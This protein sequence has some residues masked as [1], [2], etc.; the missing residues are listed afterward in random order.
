MRNTHLVKVGALQDGSILILVKK[1]EMVPLNFFINEKVNETH[2][3]LR[4]RDGFKEGEEFGDFKYKF[5]YLDT[6][7]N[8]YKRI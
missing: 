3:Y 2:L 6:L 1:E 4:E 7:Q 5:S 8:I